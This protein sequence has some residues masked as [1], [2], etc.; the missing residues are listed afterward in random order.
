MIYA[1]AFPVTFYALRHDSDD[2]LAN[3]EMA[4]V[5]A[6]ENLPITLKHHQNEKTNPIRTSS[7]Q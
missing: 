1:V 5:L 3:W 4:A 7:G 6:L 2:V